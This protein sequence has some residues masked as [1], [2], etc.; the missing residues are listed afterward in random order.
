MKLSMLGIAIVFFS[1][2]SITGN[3]WEA[4]DK[5]YRAHDAVKALALYTAIEPKTSALYHNMGNCCYALKRYPEAI[6]YWTRAIPGASFETFMKLEG[7]RAAANK[8]HNELYDGPSLWETVQ[9]YTIWAIGVL[10]V[11]G[12]QLIFLLAWSLFVIS[13]GWCMRKHHSMLLFFLGL[14]LCVSGILWYT[15]YSLFRHPIGTVVKDGVAVHAGHGKDFAVLGTLNALD[16]VRVYDHKNGWLA[17]RCHT[18]GYGWLQASD[19]EVLYI[20]SNNKN[21]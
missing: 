3:S 20:N 10:G 12:W 14:L 13:F 9:H 11:Y 15:G 19:V 6:V 18:C 2:Y 1:L 5:A 17:V 8:A 7:Y 4:A 16:S 21:Y